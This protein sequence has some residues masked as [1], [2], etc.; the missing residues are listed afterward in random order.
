MGVDLVAWLQ[1]NG[2][3]AHRADAAAHGHRP[4]HVRA[5]IRAGRV[6]RLRAQWI[7]LPSA[8]PDLVTAASA[9]ARV[10]CISLARRHGWWIPEEAT[11]RLHLHFAPNAHTHGSTAIR[12]WAAPLVDGG[13]RTLTASVEDALAHIA[14]CFGHEDARA[15]WESAITVEKLDVES[16]RAV[17]WSDQRSRELASVVRGRS[18]SGLETIFVVRLSG[19]GVPLRQQVL[20]AGHRV[21]IVI[22]SHLVIQIDGFA[23]HSSAAERGRDVAHDAELR[24]RYTVLRFTYAQILHRWDMV[25]RTVAQAIARGLHLSPAARARRA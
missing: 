1:H 18:D 7:A 9:S 5:A 22:G 16:L 13:S 24:L 11:A 21:D 14:Q 4:D 3:I 20:L 12:H 8:P 10:T 23:F 6:Q 2:G 25:E 15:V 17:R 19:W